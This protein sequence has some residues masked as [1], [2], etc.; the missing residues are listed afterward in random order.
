[1]ADVPSTVQ[2][3]AKIQSNILGWDDSE[4]SI[5]LPTWKPLG[6]LLQIV[7]W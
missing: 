3:V 1:M 6:Y 7:S 4:I 2:N 5:N